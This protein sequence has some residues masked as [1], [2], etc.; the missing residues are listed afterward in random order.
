MA[1][2]IKRRPDISEDIDL[3]QLCLKVF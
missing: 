1:T 2:S 3:L